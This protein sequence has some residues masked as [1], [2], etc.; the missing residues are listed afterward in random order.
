MMSVKLVLFNP[1][2]TNPYPLLYQWFHRI[3]YSKNMCEIYEYM[4]MCTTKTFTAQLHN[5]ISH[6]LIHVLGSD[7]PG[8]WYRGRG[9]VWEECGRSMFMYGSSYARSSLCSLGVFLV[10]VC[11]EMNWLQSHCFLTESISSH[12][13]FV[14]VSWLTLF[15][16]YTIGWQDST[17]SSE[18]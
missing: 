10:T 16:C 12:V 8:V 11:I 3:L 15:Y 18:T 17:W 14:C 1:F 7:L 6:R 4:C 13:W 5:N 2:V 9:H